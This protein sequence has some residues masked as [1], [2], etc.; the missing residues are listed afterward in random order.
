[1]GVIVTGAGKKPIIG[2]KLSDFAEGEIVYIKENGSPVEFYVVKHNYESALNGNGRTLLVRKNG[3][4][5]R[6]FDTGSS[7]VYA[8]SDLDIWFNGAYKSSLDSAVQEAISKTKFYYLRATA[9]QTYQQYTLERAVFAQSYSEIGGNRHDSNQ[10]TDGSYLGAGMKATT[11]KHWL[12]TPHTLNSN[13]TGYE[14]TLAGSTHS[15]SGV[16]ITTVYARP[17]F[18]LPENA[19]FNEKTLLFVGVK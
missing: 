15:Y 19:L 5:Q 16:G 13:Y 18:T 9:Y 17:M 10:P 2:K 4:S 3:H 8:D 12:R 1:M 7:N 6:A 11:D 14:C